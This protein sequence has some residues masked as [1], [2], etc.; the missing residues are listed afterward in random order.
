MIYLLHIMVHDGS[1]ANSGC[2]KNENEEKAFLQ[3]SDMHKCCINTRDL[4]TQS[5]SPTVDGK[6]LFP[7]H[8]FA[9]PPG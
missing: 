6:L 9:S 3:M 7:P 4:S 8:T 1:I 2:G 5:Q